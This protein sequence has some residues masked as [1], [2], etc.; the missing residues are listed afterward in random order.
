MMIG[1]ALNASAELIVYKGTEKDSYLGDGYQQQ[2]SSK[3]FLLLDHDTAEIRIILYATINGN[4]AYTSATISDL[5]IVEVTDAK[6][7]T[8]SGLSYALNSCDN[9]NGITTES[10]FLQGA[11]ASL[12][13]NT[14]SSISFP[15]SMQYS[16]R[17]YSTTYAELLSRSLSITFSS[18]ETLAANGNGESLDA[19]ESR[20][21]S[22]LETEGYVWMGKASAK[23]TLQSTD[24]RSLEAAFSRS[25]GPIR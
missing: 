1:T 2:V 21:I 13:A 19:C 4:K 16:A 24:V 23:T 25:A 18:A 10:V 20:L 3:V 22:T 12:K 6:G 11:N 17:G 8:M 14:N 7:K 9:E 5:H 15:K